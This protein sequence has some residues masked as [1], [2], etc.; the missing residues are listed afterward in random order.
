MSIFGA[1]AATVPVLGSLWDPELQQQ[2]QLEQS[3]REYMNAAS[4]AEAA[5]DAAAA[6]RHRGQARMTHNQRIRIAQDAERSKAVEC[7]KH[8]WTQ[9][10]ADHEQKAQ[11]LEY[12]IWADADGSAT[13]PQ[14]QP[15]PKQAAPMPSNTA[16][17]NAMATPPPAAA[18]FSSSSLSSSSS[19]TAARVPDGTSWPPQQQV[20]AVAPP[21]SPSLPP[22]PAYADVFPHGAGSEQK[23]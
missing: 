22:P 10:A 17:S 18:A 6:A 8:G 4:K 3:E 19:S 15:Q 23:Q 1:L 14:S 13:A 21:V 5:G 11:Q 9:A 20:A 7:R 16:S 2:R 12:E